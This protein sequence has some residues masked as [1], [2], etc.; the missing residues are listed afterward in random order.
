MPRVEQFKVFITD[1][2]HIGIGDQFVDPL[3]PHFNI[4]LGVKAHIGIEA[5]QAPPAFTLDQSQQGVADRLHHQRKRP[6]MQSP[7]VITQL[8]Q[9]MGLQLPVGAACAAK[10]VG[11]RAVGIQGDHGQGGRRG[12]FQ[13]VAAADAFVQQHLLETLTQI[14]RGEPGKQCGVDAQTL[15]ANGHVKR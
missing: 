14:V 4:R 5:D 7:Y 9:V 12:H 8:G 15:Q 6:H 2:D 3:A 13:Q 1:L 11:G 10:A